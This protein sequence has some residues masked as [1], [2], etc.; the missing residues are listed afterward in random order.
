M[1]CNLTSLLGTRD[2]NIGGQ[3]GLENSLQEYINRLV[4][5]FNEVKRVLKSDGILWINIG[6]GYTSGNRG[7]RAPDKKNPA[8]AMSVRPSTPQGLK[9]KDL[10][11]VPG[12]WPLPYNKTAG[13]S[14]AISSGINP[15]PC[16][17]VSKTG[18]PVRM[19]IFLC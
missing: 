9:L 11:G 14:A 6:D 3:I 17:K 1:R 16:L 12:G 13:I 7:W 2:Y 5:I 8:R 15:T 10:L 18:R 19:N 4:A